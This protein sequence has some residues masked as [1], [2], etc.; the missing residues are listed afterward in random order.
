M[1]YTLSDGTVIDT[2]ANQYAN[3]YGGYDAGKVSTVDTTNAAKTAELGGVNNVDSIN[4]LAFKNTDN[5]LAGT[6]WWDSTKNFFTPGEGQKT[7]VGNNM[8]DAVGT[9]VTA[10][11]GLAG[12]AL[13]Y[14][15]NKYNKMAAERAY[16]DQRKQ[17]KYLKAREAGAD[18]NKA[19]FAHAAGNGATY[20]GTVK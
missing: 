19:A 15:T 17:D 16:A 3:A 1:R 6:S 7:S 2:N 20:V 11:T 9:G 5:G 13:A 4:S 14:G 12:T 10:L 8:L 18:A